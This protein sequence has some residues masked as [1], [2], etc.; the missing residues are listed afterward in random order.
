MKQNLLPTL[1]LLFFGFTTAKAQY[2]FPPNNSST[3]DTLAPSS[4]GWCQDR[5]DSLYQVLDTNNTKAF[6]ILKNGK[7]VLEKYFDGHTASTNWYWASAGKS[8]TA[9]LVGIAQQ[10]NHLQ[11]TDTS[12]KYL[13]LGFTNCTPAQ[14]EKITIWHQLTM[15]SGLND[16]VPDPNCTIDSCLNYLATAGTRWAYHNAPYTLLDPV[17]ENATGQT[18]NQYLNQ[19]VKIPTGMDGAYFPQGFN[20]LY[21][22]T[23]RSMARFGLLILNKGNW[24]GNQILTDSVYYNAMVNTSQN[25]NLSYG[26]LWWLNGKSSFMVPQTQFV[27][28]GSFIPNAPNDMFS[29]IG[30]NGQY[31]NVVPSQDMVVIR[32]G[33]NPD[34]VLVPFLFNDVI[35]QYI[36]QL[37]C[38][39]ST[40][41][42]LDNSPK[43]KAFPNPSSDFIYLENLP[44]SGIC[45]YK[46]YNQIGKL[47]KI[48]VY[49]ERISLQELKSGVYFL[50]VLEGEKSTTLKIV[51]Q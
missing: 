28:P 45:T 46:I 31:I 34:N 43:I 26:Y 25:I 13:G 12:S 32:M 5:I 9:F 50:Q 33:D 23:A 21:I 6:I 4:L 48:G 8:L 49:N 2:Y 51:K 14:E 38:N 36:N 10:E 42:E 41:K 30:K 1:I 27:F 24:N 7:I 37:N 16:A 44:K 19:K 22:S 47:V 39:V 40:G 35:W 17:L 18:I 3:W 20:S 11:I 15:T 29:A